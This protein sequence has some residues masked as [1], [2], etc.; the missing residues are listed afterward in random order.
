MLLL[1]HFDI[2]L[3]TIFVKVLPPRAKFLFSIPLEIK[4][5]QKLQLFRIETKLMMRERR[6]CKRSQILTTSDKLVILKVHYSIRR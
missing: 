3:D 2:S 4:I 1:N 5:K 6:V